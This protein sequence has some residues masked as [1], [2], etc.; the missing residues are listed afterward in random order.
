M[1]AITTFEAETL[2]EEIASVTLADCAVAG[3]AERQPLQ[4]WFNN[5][6]LDRKFKLLAAAE[7]VCGCPDRHKELA[8]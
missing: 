4:A 5:L 3:N 8:E 7:R 2:S 6:P 1:N